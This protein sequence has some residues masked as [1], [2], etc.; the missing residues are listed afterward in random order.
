MS[1]PISEKYVERSCLLSYPSFP[2]QKLG[3]KN[4]FLGVMLML[5]YPKYLVLLATIR[6]CPT[7]CI[8][9]PLSVCA[10][11]LLMARP[12]T[13]LSPLLHLLWSSG[14]LQP[15]LPSSL[16]NTSTSL[17]HFTWYMRKV[18]CCEPSTILVPPIWGL[19]VSRKGILSPAL[20][21]THHGWG[22]HNLEAACILGRM[23]IMLGGSGDQCTCILIFGGAC[24]LL[25]VWIWILL[26]Y[27]YYV[28]GFGQLAL[29]ILCPGLLVPLALCIFCYI[30]VAVF[31]VYLVLNAYFLGALHLL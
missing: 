1:L 9:L 3:C 16:L 27:A 30:R 24:E 23:H 22:E 17:L 18:R 31:L 15:D 6:L 29:C 19:F 8:P 5:L 12:L 13:E 14:S 7:L 20:T 21:H 28:W 11:H 2:L 26:G 10:F 25:S 4:V